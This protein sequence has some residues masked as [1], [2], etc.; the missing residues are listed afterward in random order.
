M[1]RACV[2]AGGVGQL[3]SH[4]K[5]SESALHG[6]LKGTEEPPLDAFLAAVEILLLYTDSA[7]RA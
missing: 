5:V 3:A 7:G 1:H 6:W 4:L 2:I